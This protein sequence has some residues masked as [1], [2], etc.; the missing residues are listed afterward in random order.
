MTTGSLILEVV[1]KELEEASVLVVD[2]E[3]E[4]AS[5]LDN[6]VCVAAII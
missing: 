3:L 5:V 4:E 2:R 1:D 6:V